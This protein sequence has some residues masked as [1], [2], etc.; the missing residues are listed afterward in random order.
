MSTIGR[1]FLHAPAPRRMAAELPYVS[2]ASVGPIL[3]LASFLCFLPY[4]ALNIGNTSALQMGNVVS[5]MLCAPLLLVPGFIASLRPVAIILLPLVIS[6]C[7]IALG[8]G[9]ADELS[10]CVKSLASWAICGATL[11]VTL[12]FAPRHAMSMLLG[13]AAAIVLHA[14]VGAIQ[15]VSFEN[16]EMPFVSIYVNKS[17]LS[18]EENAST[19]ARYIQRPFGLFPEPSAMTS[20]IAPWTILFAA[21][22]AGLMRWPAPPRQWH[23]VL[24]ALATAGGTAL[25][26]ASRS[27]HAAFLLLGLAV[28]GLGWIRRARAGTGDVAI[29][30]TLVLVVMPIVAWAGAAALGDRLGGRSELGNSSWEER[31]T[32][33]QIGFRLMAEGGWRTAIFGMGPGLSAVE[34]ARASGLEA[35]W[36]V[37]LTYIYETGI[38]GA[39]AAVIVG[40][41]ILDRWRSIRLEPIFGSA[42]LAW[43]I[44]V[45]LTTS[46]SQLLP[47]WVTLGWLLVWPVGRSDD[48]EVIR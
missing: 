5:L 42:L 10:L 16:G 40:A 11:A 38:F 20:S 28:V 44:G 12:H 34:I 48:R 25:V 33:L 14:I 15:V 36:S 41:G 43:L 7:V 2:D 6:T 21:L 35:I 18:V 23:R 3:A 24:F 19:I 32:S 46:Y 4:P 17:F 29:L 9:G 39:I 45:T 13:I 47:L 27:G 37:L 1:D 22:S 30:A 31:A 8:V 26:I